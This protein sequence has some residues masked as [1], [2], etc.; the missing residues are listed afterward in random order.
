MIRVAVVDRALNPAALE[1]EVADPGSG[2]TSVFIGTVRDSHAGRSVT[3]IE[4]SAYTTMAER[5]LAAIAT[6]ATERT[7]VA[8]LVVE[9]R[10]GA[11]AVG[12]ASVVIALSHAH[13][14]EA[15]AA[16]SFVIEEL[17]RR[18]PIWKRE[19]YTDGTR[20]WVHASS[21]APLA[22]Q[23]AGAAGVEGRS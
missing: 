20:E 7:G 14:A 19:M 23:H 15:L 21:S 11:L 5:E 8:S 6:E 1:A 18:V 22:A 9:H 13:R 4:Y 16:T 12:E 17:K 3:G 10:I 2:A